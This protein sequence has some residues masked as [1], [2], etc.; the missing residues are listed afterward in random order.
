MSRIEYA[1]LG[2]KLSH[3]YS[4]QIHALL[5]GY[6]YELI[7]LT[8]T[9]FEDFVRARGFKGANVTIP[10]KRAALALCDRLSDEARRLGNVNT[11]VL[12]ADGLLT[13]HNTDLFGF[14][15]MVRRSGIQVTD[16]KVAVLGGSG[17][18][19]GT[20]CTAMRQ[21]GAREVLGVSRS[22]PVDYDALYALHA[23][24]QVVVNATPVGMYPECGQT[25]VDLSGLP[26]CEGVLDMIYN[27]HRTRLLMDA[28]ALG[29]KRENGLSMLVAQAALAKELF[30]GQPVPPERIEEIRAQLCREQLNLVLIGMPGSGK[31]AIGRAL[32]ASL[33]REFVDIDEQ[34]ERRAG[35]GIPEI[36]EHRGEPGF[37]ALESEL[38]AEGGKRRAL[39]IATGGG[40]VLKPENV[41]ALRQNGELVLV[42]RPL[43]QLAMDGRP[44]SMGREALQKMYAERMPVY[45]AASRAR[46]Q[47]TGTI[48]AAAQAALEGFYEVAGD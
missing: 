36:F 16:K 48:E 41:R 27:P 30:T 13:G 26:M 47:N 6:P 12:G 5:G 44:L 46:I 35:M 28:E 31:S 42:E 39:V 15:E 18:A 22:G 10:Y 2:G 34:I 20:A 17:G 24:A 29:L 9:G 38:I 4:K 19:G 21:L 3:S 43:D 7:E 33:C 14:L 32:A 1:L 37:R 45:R 23:D 40:A 8:P 25:P 11:L